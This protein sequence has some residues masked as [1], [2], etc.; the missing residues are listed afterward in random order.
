M[1]RWLAVLLVAG[2]LIIPFAVKAQNPIKLSVLQVQLWP[3]YDQ[4]SMLVI[5]DFKLPD[6]TKLPVS[7]SID[8]PKEA[9]LVAVA[10]LASDGSL[11]NTDY[12]GPNVNETWQTITIQ[13]QTSTTYHVEYYQPLSRNGDERQFTYL[14]PGDYAI[15]DISISIRLPPDTTSIKT[16]PDMKSTK[17]PDGSSNLIKDFGA[18]GAGQQ[19][20]LQIT[21]TKTSNA[22]SVPEESV[23]PS[24][25]LGS[26]TPGRVLLSNYLPY[27]LGALGVLAIGAASIYFLQPRNRRALQKRHSHG[28]RTEARGKAD[29]YC[30][31]CGARAEPGD[32]YCRVCGA[33][34]RLEE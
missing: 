33:R 12:L 32:R 19:F 18:L 31:Q 28:T 29:V 24:K 4:P 1:R 11:V 14:W 21:Y 8:F 9:N 26:N 20:P 2:A 5:Y 3:E 23:Q 7:V 6:S 22:L 10:S 27:I 30:H 34:L 16:T 13:I 15:D 17:A 25:P